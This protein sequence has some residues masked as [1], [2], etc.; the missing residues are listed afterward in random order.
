MKQQ[1]LPGGIKTP[2]KPCGAR[3]GAALAGGRCA[4][5]RWWAR[6]GSAAAWGPDACSSGRSRGR[7]WTPGSPGGPEGGAR[8]GVLAL[9]LSPP[10]AEAS[11]QRGEQGMSPVSRGG[12]GGPGGPARWVGVGESRGGLGMAWEVSCLRGDRSGWMGVR[13]RGKVRSPLLR[14]G[15]CQQV[16]GRRLPTGGR[17]SP[18]LAGKG[19]QLGCRRFIKAGATKITQTG[20]EGGRRSAPQA[21]ILALRSRTGW[22]HPFRR[23]PWRRRPPEPVCARVTCGDSAV[24]PCL[25]GARGHAG[26]GRAHVTPLGSLAPRSFLFVTRSILSKE[27]TERF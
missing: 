23:R 11:P 6:E 16:R 22:P 9:D 25:Q 4:R 7:D 20:T 10:L 18:G 21:P 8:A 13:P 19:A 12:P 5:R 15:G 26:W 1:K 14:T 17:W 27:H 24:R 3:G 2:S